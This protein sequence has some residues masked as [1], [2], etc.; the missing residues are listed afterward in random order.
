MK[1][2]I[3]L[4]IILLIIHNSVVTRVIAPAEAVPSLNMKLGA[5]CCSHPKCFCGRTHDY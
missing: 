2:L 4:A 1:L 5:G 3:N